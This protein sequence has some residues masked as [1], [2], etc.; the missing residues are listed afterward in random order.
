[1]VAEEEGRAALLDSA[2]SRRS[3]AAQDRKG[4]A[5]L[6]FAQRW[7]Q[8]RRWMKEDE[9]WDAESETGAGVELAGAAGA[10]D[11]DVPRELVAV[12]SMLFRT[13]RPFQ[14]PQMLRRGQ[15]HNCLFCCAAS[16]RA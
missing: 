7:E 3:D 14:V 12:Y 16:T 2:H 6:T 15:Y 11:D 4:K 10:V 1:M 13:V 8:M 9:R 5:R